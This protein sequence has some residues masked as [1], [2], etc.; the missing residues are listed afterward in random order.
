MAARR[1]YEDS[2]SAPQNDGLD[3][4]QGIDDRYAVGREE[5]EVGLACGHVLDELG[6]GELRDGAIDLFELHVLDRSGRCDIESEAVDALLHALRD[7]GDVNTVGI[8]GHGQVD[9][10]LFQLGMAQQEAQRAAKIVEL[11]WRG[12]AAPG[13]SPGV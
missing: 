3:R 11:L 4:R 6:E 10:L 13:Q 1:K 12:R 7:T 5:D 8:L 2:S 9:Q